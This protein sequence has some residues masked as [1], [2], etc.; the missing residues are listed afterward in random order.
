MPRNDPLRDSPVIAW[1]DLETTGSADD[2]RIIE[3]G[4]TLTDRQLVP[5]ASLR[6]VA[7]P[8]NYRRLRARMDPVVVEM[9]TANGLLD[10]VERLGES[11]AFADERIAAL[12]K[13]YN[14]SNH[15]PFAGS[16]VGH[17][18]R[19]FIK[20][21]MPQTNKRLTYWPLDIG[22]LRRWFVLWG[23]EAPESAM[24]AQAKTHRAPDDIFEHI[25]EARAYR[26]HLTMVTERARRCE[27]ACG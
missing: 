6:F 24:A 26:E 16:G 11:I 7:K 13:E 2:D 15:T 20:A 22:V 25:K 8:R 14:G 23:I 18:D 17:F 4:F 12:L 9:H 1:F 19:K 21:E 27:D 5:Q 10:D 3:V